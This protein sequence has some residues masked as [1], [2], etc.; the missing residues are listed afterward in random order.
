[1]LIVKRMIEPLVDEEQDG[2]RN[3]RGYENQIFYLGSEENVREKDL[4]NLWI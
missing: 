4:Q 2:F 1:M 3:G